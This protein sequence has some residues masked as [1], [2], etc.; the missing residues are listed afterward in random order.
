[1]RLPLPPTAFF[2]LSVSCYPAAENFFSIPK[3][4]CI[5]QH[6]PAS[7][8]KAE[9]MIDWYVH[10]YNYGWIQ[11]KTGVVPLTLHHSWWNDLFLHLGLFCAVRTIWP[12]SE[13]YTTSVSKAPWTNPMAYN[14][15]QNILDNIDPTADVVK[16]IRS[17]RRWKRGIPGLFVFRFVQLVLPFWRWLAVLIQKFSVWPPV[18]LAIFRHTTDR[19]KKGGW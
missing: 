4:K 6:K 10:F 3:T 5:Y 7:F 16:N 12:S 11:Y 14:E 18:I 1:M 19:N 17:S 13:V 15:M 8:E 9:E 2:L